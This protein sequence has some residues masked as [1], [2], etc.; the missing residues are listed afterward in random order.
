VE[1]EIKFL[2]EP[3][4]YYV[5]ENYT[6]A[7]FPCRIV[8]RQLLKTKVE[9]NLNLIRV[10]ERDPQHS[11]RDLYGVLEYIGSCM[12]KVYN[13]LIIFLFLEKCTLR[14]YYAASSGDFLPTF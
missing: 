9:N 1:F 5:R 11:S 14:S 2:I 6:Y 7:Y 12:Y 8:S 4:I 10:F 3:T 13:K